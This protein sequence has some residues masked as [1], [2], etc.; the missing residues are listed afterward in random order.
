M[1]SIFRFLILFL[2]G[3]ITLACWSMVFYY[4][5]LYVKN[6]TS[7]F[8]LASWIAAFVAPLTAFIIPAYPLARLFGKKAWVAG[9]AIG[10]PLLAV[11]LWH[12]SNYAGSFDTKFLVISA[13][14]LEGILYW[15]VLILGAWLASR[16][17]PSDVSSTKGRVGEGGGAY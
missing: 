15:L 16:R 1:H 5:E 4:C 13:A 11:F 10:W 2:L 9:A 17:W 12:T 14:A 7:N 3:V 6:L 8:R